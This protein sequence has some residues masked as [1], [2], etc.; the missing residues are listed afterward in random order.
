M[1]PARVPRICSFR[2]I[3]LQQEALKGSFVGGGVRA[4]HARQ[5]ELVGR[6][7]LRRP[8][9]LAGVLAE[10]PRIHK[11]ASRRISGHGSAVVGLAWP[12]P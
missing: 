8:R 5:I 12:G 2:S 10:K 6:P 1:G 11:A 9:L 7:A 3:V 4:K